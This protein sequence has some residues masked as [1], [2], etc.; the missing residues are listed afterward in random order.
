MRERGRAAAM[1]ARDHEHLRAVPP[2]DI[3]RR[4]SAAR[5]GRQTPLRRPGPRGIAALAVVVLSCVVSALVCSS[6]ASRT[7]C[8]VPLVGAAAARCASSTSAR[9]ACGGTRSC[10][11][12]IG[13]GG[14]V[15][16]RLIRMPQAASCPA[17]AY[18]GRGAAGLPAAA[19]VAARSSRA[20]PES[21]RD[22]L[23]AARSLRPPGAAAGH[24]HA[25]FPFDAGVA[26]V[27]DPAARAVAAAAILYAADE[28]SSALRS[29]RSRTLLRVSRVR[30][31]RRRT[32]RAGA[33]TPRSACCTSCPACSDS[34]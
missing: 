26:L 25:P 1:Y 19:H 15:R 6:R 11:R 3:P 20:T 24:V 4:V 5:V 18:A 9:S 27:A 23:P 13:A 30:L 33:A 17:P 7:C 28:A 22:P 21:A 12:W 14:T 2:S 29:R 31:E 8:L 34:S 10:T 32:R 16:R